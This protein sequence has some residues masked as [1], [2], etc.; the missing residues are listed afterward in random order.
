MRPK[1][2]VVGLTGSIGTGKSS[3]LAEFEKLGAATVSLDQV[4]REQA[5]KGREGYKAIVRDFGTCI[6][7]KDGNID[8][9]LLGRVVFNDKKA[10]LGL[11]KATHPFI[12]REMKKLVGRMNG[13]VVVDVPLLFEKKL[14]R[15]F[16]ATILIAC[17]PQKQ[18]QRILK[19]DNLSSM[20][21]RQRILAQW[22]LAKK[23]MLA[24]VTIDNDKDIRH[25]RKNVKNYHAGLQ[26]LYR[27]TPNGN[28]H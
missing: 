26:L 13:L 15:H 11:E 12:L 9:G 10:R 2:F 6:L 14:Q 17:R 20:E 23:R 28:A 24:D 8:R 22:P 4:A 1:R 21:A 7:K 16:D 27:G 19:R 18:L 5:K 25:L 3:A